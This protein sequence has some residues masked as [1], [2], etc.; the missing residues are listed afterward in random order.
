MESPI[1]KQIAKFLQDKKKYKRWLAVFVCL[2]VVV[3]FATTAALKMRGKAMTHDERVLNCKLQVHQH[4]ETCYDQE[5]NIICGYADYVVHK[6]NDDCYDP[7]NGNLVCALPE[8]EAHQ[9]TDE[10]YQ[11]QQ[12]LAC[13]LEESEG[14]QHTEECRTKEQ[15]ELTCQAEEHTHTEECQAEDGAFSC[16]KEEHTH[17]DEC[18]QWTETL[19]CGQEESEGHHHTEACN[20]VQKTLICQRPEIEVHTHGDECYQRVLITP[21]GEEIVQDP[22]DNTGVAQ[23]VLAGTANKEVPEGR[24]EVRR[25]CGKLQAEEHTHTQE[26]GCIEIREVLDGSDLRP[27]EEESAETPE[28]PAD[29]TAETPADGNENQEGNPENGQTP[30]DGTEEE[31]TIVKTFEGDGFKVI[32]EYKKDA[33]IP[34]E[35]ELKAE[36]ITAESDEAHYAEREAAFKENMKDENA[37]MKALLKVGFYVNGEEVEPQTPVTLT[38]QLLGED[39]LPEGTPMTIV[40]FADEGTKKLE[41]SKAENDTTS[42]EMESF[43]EIAIGYGED[44]DTSG[45]FIE[46]QNKEKA[47]TEFYLKESFEQNKGEFKMVFTVK[48]NIPLPEGVTNLPT[49]EEGEDTVTGN[50]SDT[51][52][53]EVG[54]AD[55]ETGNMP[56]EGGEGAE[57]ESPEEVEESTV[58]TETGEDS[59]ETDTTEDNQAVESESGTEETGSGEDLLDVEEDTEA[60]SDS[61]SPES[62]G[63]NPEAGG[64]TEEVA[65]SD[66]EAGNNL[67]ADSEENKTE[68]GADGNTTDDKGESSDA[69][70]TSSEN[71]IEVNKLKFEVKELDEKSN[72]EIYKAIREHAKKKSSSGETFLVKAFDYSLSYMGQK[73]DLSECKVTAEITPTNKLNETAEGTVVDPSE[74]KE[75][76]IEI[77]ITVSDILKGTEICDLATAKTSTTSEP[78]TIKIDLDSETTMFSTRADGMPNPHFTVQYYANLEKVA[79]NDN[80]LKE[81]TSG[82]NTNELP[83]ID[84]TGG[85][86]YLPKNGKGTENSPNGN[87]IRKLYVDTATGKLKTKSVLTKVYAERPYE[88]HKAPTI[89]YIDALIA[90]PSYELKEVW[91][92]KEGKSADSIKK[93]DWTIETYNENL[94]FTNRKL[95]EGITDGEKYIY[96]PDGATLRL[97]YDTTTNEKKLEAAFYDYDI[98]DGYIYSS[99][100]DA[101]SQTNR[102]STSTQG[103]GTWYMH[104]KQSGINSPGNYTGTGAKLAFGNGNS[105]S[106]LQYEDWNGNLLNKHN[107]TQKDNP[108]VTGSYKGLTFGLA[109]ALKDGKIVYASEVNAPKL[110]N[111]DGEV[112]GKTAYDQYPL[113]FDRVGDTHTLTSVE[114]TGAT[115]LD[116]F[117]NPDSHDWVGN[118]KKHYHIWTN[119][120]WPMDSVTSYGADGHDMK[121]GYY[122]LR[123]NRKYVGQQGMHKNDSTVYEGGGPTGS[124]PQSDDD[125]DH[126]SYFGMHYKVEFDLVADYVGPLEYYFFGDDDMWVFLS[127]DDNKTGKLVCD[128]GGVHSSVGEY[129]NLWD[130][131]D[132]EAE[133][134]HRHTDECYENGVD[135]P[136]TCG[137]VDSKKFTLNFFYTERGESGSSCWMQFTLPSVSS[138]TPE[139]TDEDFGHL[140]VDKDIRI[141][142]NDKDYTVEDFFKDL[143]PN[144]EQ[145]G[146]FEK[147]EFTFRLTLQ[148][149]NGTTLKDDYA[150]V[151]YG[152]DGK[153]ITGNEGGGI[154]A[155]ET[156]ANGETFTLKDG[157]YIRIQYLPQG[158][159]YTIS[160]DKTGVVIQGVVYYGTDN[161]VIEK[162][163]NTDE[164]G[165]PIITSTGQYRE[166]GSGTWDSLNVSGTIPVNDTTLVNYTNK[167]RVYELPKTGGEGTILYTMAGV[168]AILLG[169]GFM[170]RKKFREGRVGG[171]S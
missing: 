108:A 121:F 88:Y 99:E 157:Q 53:E 102:K 25:S 52:S 74:K 65:N 119:N 29:G 114:G 54:N 162:E 148:G 118:P 96:I 105:G 136:P 109:S 51:D 104:T 57:E 117:N 24:I 147:K 72:K 111:E 143:D 66:N 59:L 83:V 132:K 15:G 43:S 44:D 166:D 149:P 116:S 171:S 60:A 47:P 165:N 38:V 21:E 168:A 17:A 3:G 4:A 71:G 37:T 92:L 133:K 103:D 131:I 30:M 82:T 93:D 78:K 125:Q 150:Y 153:P 113:V 64:E 81:I 68:P 42:F 134:I 97:V 140:R 75:K 7:H 161:S 159:T 40:H 67:P 142:L 55:S 129:L 50:E 86:A 76:D 146:Y 8:V 91:I 36:Q 115:G 98:G 41:G 11:E 106:G 141:T 32:A 70:N 79:Y 56:E 110:F 5:K 1:L 101:A 23:E 151:K 120:F 95:S 48:G 61:N 31:Q 16:G 73:L 156:I 2:A 139:T 128:I 63:D 58:G 122:A 138:L 62:E 39:G 49:D 124:F 13:G 33:N 22:K 12:A 89:N 90:N 28:A 6:H 9:H 10:C 80:N 137:Y 130:Y 87:S 135:N 155:W 170:Y 164:H 77:S 167:Y 85:E 69:D 152:K 34:E 27:V 94:H 154:L 100:S 160:E 35:A 158:T 107:G 169:A 45:Q 144:S 19:T 126:N 14:H 18:Y 145:K 123:D 127:N 20:Q 163:K 84:T 26:N 46:P 112:T